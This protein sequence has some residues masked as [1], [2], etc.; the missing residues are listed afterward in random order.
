M[1]KNKNWT[2]LIKQT[3]INKSNFIKQNDNSFIFL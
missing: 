2:N 1:I 3:K